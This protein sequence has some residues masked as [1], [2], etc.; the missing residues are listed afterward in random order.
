MGIC[1]R[2]G[3]QHETRDMPG[4]GPHYGEDPK[5]PQDGSAAYPQ[6]L[7]PLLLPQALSLPPPPPQQKLC[8]SNGNR[9]AR[10]LSP[11]PPC[12]PN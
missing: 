6:H 4:E 5:G 2:P 10:Q 1:L 9:G 8:V 12:R 7:P 11:P 3:E